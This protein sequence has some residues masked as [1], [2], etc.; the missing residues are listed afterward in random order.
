MAPLRRAL[1]LQAR[2]LRPALPQAMSVP[3]WRG[4]ARKDEKHRKEDKKQKEKEQVHSQFE[5]KDADALKLEFAA[6][7]DGALA[8][9]KAQLDKVKSG[10][11]A[12]DIFDHVEVA[13]YGQKQP[14]SQVGQVIVKGSQTLLVKV[15]DEAVRDE[16][17]KALTRSEF[18]ATCTA[19]GK[20]V[21]VKLGASKKEVIEA[22]LRQLKAIHEEFK[23]QSQEV[24]H[25]TKQTLKKLEKILPQDEVKVI[26]REFE[27]LCAAKEAD[28][29]KL[30]E[31][32]ERE[33]RAA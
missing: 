17:I 29:K 24:R 2:F 6:R 31:A 26:A 22:A 33:I 18:D 23:E 19:E 8:E 25:E 27:K 14:F 1:F 32:K 12:P 28:A 16:V 9:A 4:F 15:F 30:I 13:A 7:F 20:D 5:G 11:A 10:R 3:Q 21:R